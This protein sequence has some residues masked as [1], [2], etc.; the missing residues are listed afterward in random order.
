M[1]AT[2][3]L[4]SAAELVAATS[5]PPEGP[6]SLD[7]SRCHC[8]LAS[9]ET[10]ASPPWQRGCGSVQSVH[11]LGTLKHDFLHKVTSCRKTQHEVQPTEEMKSSVDVFTGKTKKSVGFPL[12]RRGQLLKCDAKKT[13]PS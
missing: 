5:A 9:V 11:A 12:S 7:Q 3:Y 6:G 2:A 8:C 10:C 13:G 4:R 1:E